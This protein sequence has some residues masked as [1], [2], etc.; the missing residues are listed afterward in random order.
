M[1]VPAYHQRSGSSSSRSNAG[2]GSLLGSPWWADLKKQTRSQQHELGQVNET[3]I[4]IAGFFRRLTSQPCALRK[5]SGRGLSERNL[6]QMRGFY[7]G[8]CIS[9]A[10]PAESSPWSR[11]RY[12]LYEAPRRRPREGGLEQRAIISAQS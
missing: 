2:H 1:D 3:H 8:W 6:K 4:R 7:L 5:R 10:A 12:V 9:Q 11:D